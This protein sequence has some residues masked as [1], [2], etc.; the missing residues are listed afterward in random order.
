MRWDGYWELS[1][2]F[3]LKT[4]QCYVIKE[5]CDLILSDHK[6]SCKAIH[7]ETSRSL[8]YSFLYTSKNLQCLL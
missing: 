5:S 2:E 6:I 3:S 4:M 8:I 7:E 1:E